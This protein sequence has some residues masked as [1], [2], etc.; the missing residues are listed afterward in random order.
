MFWQPVSVGEARANRVLARLPPGDLAAL[1]ARLVRAEPPR[2]A[3]LL[4]AGG[5]A[6][7]AFFP[8]RGAALA[9]V[10]APGGDRPVKVAVVGAEGVAGAMLALDG[11]PVHAGCSVLVSGP[12][13]RLPAAVLAEAATRSPALRDGLARAADMM[14]A[15]LLQNAACHALHPLPQRLA[16]W[17]LSVEERAGEGAALAV[18]QQTLA[19]LL[20]AQRTSVTAAMR[21]LEAAGAIRAGRGRVAVADRAALLRHACGCHAA[22]RRYAEALFGPA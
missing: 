6:S 10:V 8:S 3:A 2:G 13:L 19:G 17:V 9:L 11:A 12:V 21:G 14:I 18:T 7:D 20:A 4:A 15:Q 22:L 1:S 16:R 5:R